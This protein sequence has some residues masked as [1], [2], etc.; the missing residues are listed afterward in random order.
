MDDSNRVVRLLNSFIHAIPNGS[1]LCLV[2]ELLGPSVDYVIRNDYRPGDDYEDDDHL[3]PDAI[4][5]IAKQLLE[6]LAFVHKSG[7]T[8]GGKNQIVALLSKPSRHTGLMVS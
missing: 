7:Y 8:Q 4:F 5:K 1:H 6:G 2:L 3:E